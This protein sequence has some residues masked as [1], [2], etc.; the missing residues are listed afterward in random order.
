M[1]EKLLERKL[2]EAVKRKGGEALKLYSAYHTGMPDRLVLMPGG[3]ASFAE[4][5]TTG[6]KPTALQE[7]AMGRLRAM[8]FKAEVVDTQEA[9]DEFLGG[10]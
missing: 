6:R 2:R 9:L 4:T 1:K 8:G 3:K 7:K 5:K 10:L